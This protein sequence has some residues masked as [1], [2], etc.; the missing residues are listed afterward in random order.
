METLFINTNTVH[1]EKA[2][3]AFANALSLKVFSKKEVDDYVLG[4]YM[5]E[6][7]K[8]GFLGVEKTTEY[9]KN[10]ENEIKRHK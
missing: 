7:R 9:I 2:V 4:K 5:E 8:S 10:L 1:D 6:C 3:R